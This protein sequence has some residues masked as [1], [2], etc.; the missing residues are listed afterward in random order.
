[1]NVNKLAVALGSGMLLLSASGAA[2]ENN[3][4][5]SGDKKGT[6]VF[7]PLNVSAGNITREQEALEK[8]GA[9]SSRATDKNLQS[10]D[11]TLRSM[12][13]TYTQ[14]DPGQGTVSVNIRGM[15]GFGRVNTMVDGITQSFYGTTTS[16]TTVHGST[17]NQAGV[18]IDPNFLVGVDVIRGDSSGSAGINALTG[19]ANMR[20]LGVD[21]VIFK[22]ND[23]G[24]RS[25]FSVGSNGI[26]RSGMISAAGKT[27]AFTDTGSF[28]AM[29]AI[30]GSSIY[31]NF[32]NG[33]GINSEEFG[34]DKFMKQNPKSQLYKMDIKPDEFNSFELSARTYNNRF[35]RRDITSDDYY[36]KY[37]Y[38]P[39]TELIDFKVAA[40]TSRGDQKYRDDSLYTFYRTSAQNRSDALDISNVSRFSLGDNDLAFTLGGKLMR[41]RY[42]RIINSAAGDEKTNQESIENN[43]FAPSGQQDISA[44]YTGLQ[45]KRGIW[46][47]DLNLN[48]THNRITGHKPPCDERVICVPQGSY[49]V[50][51]RENGFNPSAQLSAQVTPWLQPFVGYSK[52]MRAPNIQE[53]FFSNSGGASMNPFLKPELAET[54]QLGF[55]IDT[56]DLIAKQDSL[57]F[58]L[59]GYR[60]RIQNYIF[61]ESYQVCSS[62]RKCS[63]S[64]VIGNGWADMSEDYSD[65]MYIYVNSATGVTAQGVE[66]EM[67]Y[68]AGFAF[69]RL[70]FSQQLTDQPTSIASTYFGA[71]DIT[72]LPR[73][74]M[75]LDAGVRFFDEALT[76]GT[77]VKYTGK[78]RR[79][80]PDFEPDEQTGA[81]IKE[82]LPQIPT[83]IDLYGTYEVNRNLMLKLTVQNLM[84]RD[85]SEALNKLNMMPGPGDDAS[86]ANTA[87]GRTWIFGGEVRF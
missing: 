68:D 85:Y 74:Y 51:E 40:S 73:K 55:N 66:L 14:I 61:S 5:G 65:N 34:Y 8:P 53:M 75:T 1:M 57:R 84:N 25:R 42:T 43:P 17:N 18:L 30:S 37:H 52:S 76:L 54:W 58:K 41:T 15:S 78:A 39:F 4:K 47:A 77:I 19:S 26:G 24:L 45:V 9:T 87:R 12:P 79:M 56:K 83:I 48:Y 82:D 23:Y 22:G 31:S 69:T 59:L 11:A 60:S 80:S 7:S 35:S 29:A 63:M 62:G 33:S 28:G 44:L 71:G 27:D 13:G 49:E 3:D 38:A 10:L 72:E 50:D 67:D 16:G 64:E 6:A 32:S 46:Q 36:I 21:D 2:Q 20:T 81:I 86:R 70:S